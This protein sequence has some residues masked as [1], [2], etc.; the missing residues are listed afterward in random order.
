MRYSQIPSWLDK[1]AQEEQDTATDEQDTTEAGNSESQDS[2]DDQSAESS[3]QPPADGEGEQPAEGEQQPSSDSGV[4]S[5]QIGGEIDALKKELEELKSNK[6]LEDEVERLKKK[7]DNIN[8]DDDTNLND[9]IYQSA[10]KV[11]YVKRAMRRIFKKRAS[12]LTTEQQEAVMNELRKNGDIPYQQ[13]AQSMADTIGAKED[14]IFMF[15]TNF[16]NSNKHR[17]DL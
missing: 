13:L 12:Y 9:S 2:G 3:D 6:D 16:A 1:L 8:I 7:I 14:D 11:A 15:L 10:S 4:T 17:R 5:E